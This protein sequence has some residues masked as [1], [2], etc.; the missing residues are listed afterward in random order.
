MFRLPHAGR[1]LLLPLAAALLSAPA[2]A[3]ELRIAVAANFLGTLQTMAPF[4]EQQSG[5][6]LVIS[7][8]ASGQL[9]AQISQG[10]PF[11]VFLSADS[12]RPQALE[13]QGLAE[14][15]SRFTYAVGKLVLWSAT[16]G[17]FGDGAAYL[18]ADQFHYLAIA[19]PE[20]APYGVAARQLL[21][22]LQLWDSLQSRQKIVM[23]SSLAQAQQFAVTG[24]AEV[25]F[26]AWSQVLE[27]GGKVSGS[28]W[29]PPA[30]LYAPI[31][32]QAVV[33]SSSTAKRAARHFLRWLRTDTKALQLLQ[34]AGYGLAAR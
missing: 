7:A 4:Y 22:Q 17:L 16:P 33:L 25:A 21:M 19:N 30:T 28:S 18:R 23:G 32:Q 9:Y 34:S 3:G 14:R 20:V 11:D 2:A 5:D 26:V 12:E 6:K 31:T 15:G 13:Q 24:N 27:P 29:L 1:A 10:A 8:A